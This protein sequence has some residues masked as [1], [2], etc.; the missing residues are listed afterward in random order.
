MGERR[1]LNA[2]SRFQFEVGIGIA[3]G[4]VVAGCMGSEDRL[5][6]TVLGERVNLASRLCSEAGST[7]LLIDETTFS[8]LPEGFLAEATLPL[9]LKGY[10]A[11][12]PAYRLTNIIEE[13]AALP[14]G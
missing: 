11:P 1:E 9:A 12:V 4:E 14:T 8:M 6:Y 2:V 3:T 7:E 10:S 5:N 13:A